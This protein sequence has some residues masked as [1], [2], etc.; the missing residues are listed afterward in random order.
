MKPMATERARRAAKATR[1]DANEIG[2]GL[3]GVRPCAIV[4]TSRVLRSSWTASRLMG[5]L[6]VPTR[7]KLSRSTQ[8]RK[9]QTIESR[10]WFRS[11]TPFR[12]DQRQPG[13]Q[14]KHENHLAERG[15]VEP[16]VEL[17]AAPQAGQ[18]KGKT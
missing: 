15:V 8:T 12:H 5:R 6:R 4:S 14:Q 18:Q 16:A 11:K 1:T 13:H 2:D 9:R 7:T 17:E 3:E 10:R